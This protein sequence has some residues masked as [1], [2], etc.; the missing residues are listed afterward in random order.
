MQHLNKEMEIIRIGVGGG[1]H[2]CTEAVFQALHGVINVEQGYISS[3]GEAVTFSEGVIISFYP[4]QIPL[5]KI[6]EIHLSTHNSTS[7][8]SF[9]TK[10]RSAIYFM[11]PKEEIAAEEILEELQQFSQK[12]IIT[13]VLPLKEFK[14]SRKEIRNYYQSNPEKVF[15]TRYIHPKLKLLEK[16]FN[17]QLIKK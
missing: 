3:S 14:P 11:N 10:Y 9:R 8:H 13:Q 16:E 17:D 2:W 4:A 5:K 1:C 7:N 12:K 6:I 15:C